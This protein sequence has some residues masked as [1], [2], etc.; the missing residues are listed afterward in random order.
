MRKVKRNPMKLINSF[1]ELD[2]IWK[3]FGISSPDDL[4][5]LTKELTLRNEVPESV[6]KEFETIKDLIIHSYSK[7]RFL[8][9][10]CGKALFTFEMALKKRYE[11]IEGSKCQKGL[12]KLITWAIKNNL[13]EEEEHQ[14]RSLKDLR[15]KSAHP[16][17]W[18]L[19]GNLSLCII[20]RIKNII[21]GLYEDSELTRSRKSEYDRINKI[22]KSF[23]DNGA[24]LDINTQGFIVFLSQLVF[25]DNIHSPAI[26]YFLFY[27]IFDLT[28]SEYKR[29]DVSPPVI[30]KTKSYSRKLGEMH[31]FGF[32]KDEK[33]ILTLIEK[34]KD[35]D[36]FN[37]WMKQFKEHK[38]PI[39]NEI[40]YRIAKIKNY[41]QDKAF[42]ISIVN[43]EESQ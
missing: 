41:L 2:S 21:N 12:P 30:F 7:Y 3:K 43:N 22:L 42:K 28:I 6:K 4:R 1:F 10:A 26:Y 13:F 36:R 8:D 33:I 25:Y 29:V 9:S 37:K 17:D 19:L 14:I 18:K 32:S 40:Q 24:I 34:S 15:D 5:A 31:F 27:P 35:K 11:E 38:F 23:N 39:R 20:I 16:E